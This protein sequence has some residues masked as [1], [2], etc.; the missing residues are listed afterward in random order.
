MRNTN[1]WIKF[2][3]VLRAQQLKM[4]IHVYIKSV[5]RKLSRNYIK[6]AWSVYLRATCLLIDCCVLDEC[7]KNDKIIT[8]W[9]YIITLIYC[10]KIIMPY[11]TTILTTEHSTKYIFTWQILWKQFLL[12]CVFLLFNSNNHLF[13]P[14]RYVKKFCRPTWHLSFD[15]KRKYK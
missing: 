13:M 9:D 5:I 14:Q 3:H 6:I 7:Q 4:Y 11:Y 1:I 2:S 12:L 15:I 10:S 8:H